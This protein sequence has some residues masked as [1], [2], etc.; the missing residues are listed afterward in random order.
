MDGI[1]YDVDMEGVNPGR[2]DDDDDDGDTYENR[3][4]LNED[5][6]RAK[7]I[8]IDRYGP[9][10]GPKKLNIFQKFKKRYFERNSQNYARLPPGMELRPKIEE[11]SAAIGVGEHKV[12]MKAFMDRERSSEEAIKKVR[13]IY[14]NPDLEKIIVT[15]EPTSGEAWDRLTRQGSKNWLLTDKKLPKT[16]KSALGPLAKD[17]IDGLNTKIN[18]EQKIIDSGGRV[19]REERVEPSREKRVEPSREERESRVEAA[20]ETIEVSNAEIQRIEERL[21]LKDR[22]K[23]IFEKHGVTAFAI[24][25]SVGIV[26][27]VVISSLKSGLASLATGLGSGLKAIGSKLAQLLPGMVGAIASFNI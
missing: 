24:A 23:H 27:G 26:L 16:L 18:A 1:D 14:Y 9:E 12:G 13:E 2:N 15:T 22:I 10:E 17:A 21:S 3:Q 19:E 6:D 5:E 8:L 4:L 7:Y 20:R 25:S 11:A